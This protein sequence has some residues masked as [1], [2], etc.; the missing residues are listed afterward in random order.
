MELY[1]IIKLDPREVKVHLAVWNGK[2]DPL[3]EY[4]NNSFK[5][6]QEHQS[7]RN[8]QRKY[9]VSLIKL[10][11][12]SLW[13][14]AGIYLSHGIYKSEEKRHFY[15]TEI[16]DIS[17]ELNGRLVV[18]YKRKG[19]NSYPNGESLLGC[20]FVHEIR[21]EALAFA[22]FSNF[23]E[24][25]LSRQQIEF[26]F[27]N[28]CSSWKAALSSVSGV[29]LLSDQSTGR[30]YVGSAYSVGGFWSRWSDYYS[31]YHGGNKRLRELY[32]TG[33]SDAFKN[34]SYSILETCDLDLPKE[35]VISI[36]NRWKEKLLTRRF[37]YN[38]N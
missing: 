14:F 13:L 12:D 18:R 37:G 35:Q 28:Q 29:Y 34:F 17:S 3:D 24:V 32:Q 33:G 5:E 15:H 36:E 22:D 2:V 8:F 11:H 6:W 38:E 16:T 7:K 20:A 19:R 31:N 26:L 23:K 27:L 21:A 10:S 1:E 4:F 9:I 25:Q 30:L